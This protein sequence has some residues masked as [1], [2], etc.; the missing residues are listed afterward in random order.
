[1]RISDWSSDVGSSD[2][3][4][5]RRRRAPTERIDITALGRNIED[6]AAAGVERLGALKPRADIF[7]AAAEPGEIPAQ[8]QRLAARRTN[9]V[10]AVVIGE[11][12]AEQ[13]G[14]AIADGVAQIAACAERVALVVRKS[15]V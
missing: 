13:R 8:G 14:R 11:R 4:V 12:I 9:A 15:V 1:M 6:E 3:R 2:L 10:V 7:D 5:A